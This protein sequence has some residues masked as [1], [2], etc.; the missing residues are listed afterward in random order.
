M[1]SLGIS[2]HDCT[3]K[4]FKTNEYQPQTNRNIKHKNPNFVTAKGL[5]VREK[6]V[7]LG[8]SALQTKYFLC[9][10]ATDIG[11]KENRKIQEF[12]RIL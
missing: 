11:F 4:S 5:V 10:L 1:S 6:E 8:Q 2:D 9:Y 3:A 7:C 12:E